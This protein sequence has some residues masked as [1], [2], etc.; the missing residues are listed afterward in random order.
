MTGDIASGVGDAGNYQGFCPSAAPKWLRKSCDR[1]VWADGACGP[2]SEHGE[3]PVGCRDAPA[4]GRGQMTLSGA[5]DSAI[6][7]EQLRA[8]VLKKEVGVFLS[9]RA[10]LL[11]QYRRNLSRLRRL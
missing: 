6:L 4:H 10:L 2:S 8:F 11:M 9:W 5:T 1:S 7:K 3:M